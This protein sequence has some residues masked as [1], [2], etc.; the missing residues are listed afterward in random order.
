MLSL[1]G[2]YGCEMSRLPHFTDKEL[3]DVIL[4]DVIEN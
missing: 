2:P 4:A 3:A 1:A